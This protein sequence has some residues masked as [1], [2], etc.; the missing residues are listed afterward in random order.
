MGMNP[1]TVFKIKK[2]LTDKST[3]KK[4]D[5]LMK[6][7]LL[8]DKLE[9]RIYRSGYDQAMLAEYVCPKVSEG[10]KVGEEMSF[11]DIS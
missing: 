10:S 1:F 9:M 2:N 3:K 8:I 4:T 11:S 6:D 7:K 5:D